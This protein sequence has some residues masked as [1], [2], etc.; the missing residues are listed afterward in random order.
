VTQGAA[1]LILAIGLLVAAAPLSLPRPAPERSVAPPD[2]RA[3]WV[4]QPAEPAALVAWATAND[5]RTI[6]TYVD[7]KALD[8]PGLGRLR[9]LCDGHGILL[10]ALGGEPGWV[11]DPAAATRWRDAVER[12]GVFHGLHLDVEPYLLPA[13]NSDR[14]ATVKRFLAVLDALHGGDRPLELDVPFWYGTVQTGDRTLADE[15]LDRVDAVT[16]MS[17][18][19]RPTGP[20]SMLDVSRDLLDRAARAAKPVRLAAETQPLA[21]CAHCTFHGTTRSALAGDLSTAGTA[22]QR[23]PAFAGIAVHQYSTWS[24]L[25]R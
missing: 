5:V 22:A 12:L 25:P 1:G 9:A 8:A 13:W 24:A 11:L 6:F 2:A 15:V 23:F 7:V 3:M 20:N 21:D 10:D 19:N 17:Y 16:V 14:A 18:R 4:W